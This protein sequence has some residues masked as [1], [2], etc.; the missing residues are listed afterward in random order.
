MC[1]C[2]VDV[3]S[4]SRHADPCHARN[5]AHAQATGA[6]AERL[7]TENTELRDTV[8]ELRVKQ[9][10]LLKDISRKEEQV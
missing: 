3:R 8:Q 1:E 4:L 2:V 7:R 10:D 6:T 5:S 9:R